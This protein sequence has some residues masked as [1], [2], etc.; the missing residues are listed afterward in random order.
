M[1]LE[2]AY[3][4]F[5]MSREEYCSENTIYNYKHTITYFLNFMVEHK[6][7]ALK[8]I[9]IETI[10]KTDLSAYTVYLRDKPKYKNHPFNIEQSKGITKRSIK[11][12]Q[13]DVRTFFNFLYDEEYM[14]NHISRKYKIISPEKKQIIPL[15]EHDVSIIDGL[16]NQKTETG[17]RNLC[18]VHLM[19]D[20]GLRRSEVINLQLSH[21]NFMQ[22]YILIIDG[23]G[24]KDRIIPLSPRL[25]K[26]LYTYK[27]VYR[28]F[29]EHSYFLCST[30]EHNQLSKDCIKMLFTRMKKHTDLKRLYPHLLRHTFATSYIMQGGDLESLRIYMGHSDISITQKY[31]HLANQFGFNYD[32]YKLDKKFFHRIE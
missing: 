20:A 22:N 2:Q 27:E 29:T 26:M 13:T 15:T 25:K 14:K 17:L 32:I 21:V 10:D 4:L 19:L 6:G 23:K 3:N 8:E 9:D 12:Y 18:I 24:S 5:I 30:T 28:P 1:N 31:L 16:Y 7:K 11:T